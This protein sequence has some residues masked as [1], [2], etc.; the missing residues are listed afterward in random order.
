MLNLSIRIHY[1]L[2]SVDLLETVYH[3]NSVLPA[4]SSSWTSKPPPAIRYRLD[5]ATLE[6]SGGNEGHGST[7]ERLLAWEKK[8]YE[9]VK[10]IYPLHN[11]VIYL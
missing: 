10:T 3:S 5:I 7:L 9:Q 4:L 2:V 6:E 11:V 1:L 8:L